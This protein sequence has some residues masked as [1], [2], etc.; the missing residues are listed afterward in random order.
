MADG[1][2]RR[3]QEHAQR[4]LAECSLFRGLNADERKGLVAKARVRTFSSGDTVFL[5]GSQGDSMMA[6]LDGR[7]R[8]SVSSPAGKEIVLA[9]MHPGDVFGEIA[10]LD[11]KGR[12]ADA[13][14]VSACSL[15]VLERRD[16]LTFFAQ[17]PS[18][19]LGLVQVLCRRLR[20]S[21]EQTTE[22]AL[23]DLPVRLA[24]ALLR[25]ATADEGGQAARPARQIK[26]SQRELGNLIG[27]T[28]ESINKCLREWQRIGAVK[29]ENNFITIKNQSALEKLAELD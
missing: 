28:R 24:K 26:L 12:S 14:A 5:M 8:I 22:V 11:G 15:A 23:L 20:D 25:L 18:A 7:V 29:I 9:I 2:E 21:T 17:H 1:I 6:V 10:L 19:W 4:L 13:K 27:A 3:T 16:V